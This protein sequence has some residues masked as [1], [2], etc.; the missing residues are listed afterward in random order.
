[1][2]RLREDCNHFFDKPPVGKGTSHLT[3]ASKHPGQVKWITCK[4]IYLCIYIPTRYAGEASRVIQI[5]K[6]VSGVHEVEIIQY[7][8]GKDS[9]IQILSR[10]FLNSACSS[11]YKRVGLEQRGR[12]LNNTHS[13]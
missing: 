1:M 5:G 10:F 4:Q 12:I 11:L 9:L 8:V 13:R 7:R 2:L 6:R 3:L